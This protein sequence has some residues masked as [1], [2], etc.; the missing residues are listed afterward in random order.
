MPSTPRLPR[1][2]LAGLTLALAVSTAQGQAVKSASP[3]TSGPPVALSSYV[4][5]GKLIAYFE[6][7]G[8]DAHADAWKKT[9]AYKILNDTPT[10]VMLEDVLAQLIN[11]TAVKDSGLKV[12]GTESV[13]LLK[14]MAKNGFV[15]ALWDVGEQRIG[16]IV[17]V[18]GAFKNKEL[19]SA[20]A[21]LLGGLAD[22]KVK[23]RSVDVD[24][25]KVIVAKTPSGGAVGYWVDDARKEDLILLPN[26]FNESGV[27]Q[28][29]GQVFS[30]LD[31]KTPSARDNPTRMALDKEEDGFVSV[32]H[33]FIS[34][35]LLPPIPAPPALGLQALK[36]MDFRWGFQD[37]D[38]VSITRIA[39]P[40][41]RQGV[42]ALFDQPTFDKSSLPP[43][44]ESVS[45][46]S[47]FSF[48]A[49]QTFDQITAIAK[50][51]N[52]QAGAQID[53]VVDLVKTKTRLRLKE[54]ILAHIGPKVAVYMAPAKAGTS[55]AP[56]AGAFNPLSVLMGGAAIP[57]VTIVADIDNPTAFSKTLDELMI[58]V[59]QTLR[60]S[61]PG[62]GGP[63]AKDAGKSSRGPG[64]GLEFKLV[65]GSMK[66][67]ML[68]VPS[69]LTAFLP[70]YVRPTIR[71]GPKHVVI[72]I[73]PEAARAALEVKGAGAGTTFAT[74]LQT[75]PANLIFLAVEDPS[76]SLS[77]ALASFPGKLQ[78][79]VNKARNPAPPMP[80]PAMAGPGVPGQPSMPFA[81][82]G[83]GGFGSSSS[84][85]DSSSRPS[86][87]SYPGA[88]GSGSSSGSSSSGMP[89]ALG[90]P[91]VPGSGSGGANAAEEKGVVLRVDPSKMPTAA[92]IKALLFPSS[93][94][95]AIE[96]AGLRIVTREAFPNIGSMVSGNSI[97]SMISQR[98]VPPAP[99]GPNPNAVPGSV[100]AVP[101]A[102]QPV[103]PGSS[104][105]PA[106]L[107]KPRRPD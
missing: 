43:I 77:T 59:N 94:S 82:G 58:L 28:V 62:P 87:P 42:L 76:E 98:L 36:G 103:A 26:L 18:R 53:A 105:G 2:A 75:T 25:H 99:G 64:S 60:S 88:P 54:D 5:G 9:A 80:M 70:T 97:G 30:T 15:A 1:L 72:S 49:K 86:M 83:P 11:Q 74:A 23:A 56:K 7:A 45:E 81:P 12:N 4:P 34:L 68:S 46:F 95:V 14:H 20:I 21:R 27:V 3:L 38:L 10:G 13:A 22:P 57:R 40:K 17:V 61:M 66:A 101:G 8:L 44:P 78:A 67:F 6:F 96:D 69:E 107:Q 31:G 100:G 89:G 52:P 48:D 84:S 39:A 92:A 24:G 106:M 33:G 104:G 102:A 79:A 55:D 73:S 90:M 51:M 50:M 85:G 91:G 32:G 65:P 16:T 35:G 93:T 63:A 41:P 29:A 71:V 47:V 37:K 19:R